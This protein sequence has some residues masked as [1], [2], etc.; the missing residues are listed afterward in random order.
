MT[1]RIFAVMMVVLMSSNLFAQEGGKIKES[2]AHIGLVYP[3]STNWVDAMNYKNRFSVHILAGVSAAED[4]FCASGVANIIKYNGNGLVAAGVANVILENAKGF[5]AAG[6]VNYIGKEARGLQGAGF[7]NITGSSIGFQ[8]GGFANVNMNKMRGLQAAGFLNYSKQVDGF[9]AGGFANVA[10]KVEGAQVA[11]FGNVAKDVKGA[12]VSGYF[13][14]AKKVN[15]QVSGFLNI[16][17]EVK[18]VQ[19]SGFMNIADS[20]DFPVG[21]IN[22]S[23]KGEKFIGVT[24][25]DNATTMVAFRSGGKYLYGIVGMGANFKYDNE[26]LYAVEAGIGGHIPI[27]KSFRINAEVSTTTLTDFWTTVQLTSSL[28]VLPAVKLGKRLELF[29]GPTFNYES[30][31]SYFYPQQ[32]SYNLWENNKWGYYQSIYIGAMAGLHF[33]I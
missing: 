6:Y 12:Q 29:G 2:N 15:T 17:G 31:D 9:Q 14:V 10:D 3:L 13:N 8:A 28:R 27:A 18:G 30:S 32:R 11:G 5:Q 24:I 23:R 26:P 21:F 1:S 7:A 16:A 22:I 20:C 33:D 19:V 4:A 25:D